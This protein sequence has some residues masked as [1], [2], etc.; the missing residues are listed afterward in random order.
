MG[1]YRQHGCRR[2][3]QRRKV[4]H[5]FVPLGQTFNLVKTLVDG[6]EEAGLYE[7]AWKGGDE[8]GLEVP[9]GHQHHSERRYDGY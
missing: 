1:F 9:S 3:G 2:H 8:T 4:R 6:L 5:R 7:A